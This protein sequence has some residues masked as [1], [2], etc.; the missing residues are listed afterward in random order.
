MAGL[1]TEVEGFFNRSCRIV[2]GDE[3]IFLQPIAV[4]IGVHHPI[5]VILYLESSVFMINMNKG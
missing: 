1:Q 3:H 4:L 2:I 5:G